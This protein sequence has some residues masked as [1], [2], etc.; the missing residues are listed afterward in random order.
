MKLRIIVGT[1]IALTAFSYPAYHA[2]QEHK[3]LAQYKAALAAPKREPLLT[4]TNAVFLVIDNAVLLRINDAEWS[5]L[6][7]GYPTNIR[8]DSLTFY[9]R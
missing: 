2:W 7:N 3:L 9:K 5:A 8:N 1:V 6:T 4:L